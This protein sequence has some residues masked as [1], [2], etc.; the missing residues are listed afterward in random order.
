[1]EHRSG[2][3]RAAVATAV[4]LAASIAVMWALGGTDT[5]RPRAL[6]SS[7]PA[8]ARPSTATTSGSASVAGVTVEGAHVSLGRVPLNTTVTPTWV[9]RNG[10]DA[11]VALGEPKAVVAEGCCPGPLQLSSAS[12]PPRGTAT[13]AFPL[14]MHPGMDGPHDFAVTV[15][16]AGQGAL[17][18]R[19]TGDFR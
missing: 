12:L 1:M 18:L 9:I 5:A 2:I 11:S 4:S 6:E 16:V 3:R 13:L 10:T 15:P 7:A 19:V 17:A 14:Q 8:P